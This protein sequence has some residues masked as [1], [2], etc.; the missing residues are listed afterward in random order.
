MPRTGGA[1]RG[2]LPVE[3]KPRVADEQPMGLVPCPAGGKDGLS[4]SESISPST[5]VRSSRSSSRAQVFIHPAMLRE[6]NAGG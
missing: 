5:S 4:G 1:R 6:G 3:G 2:A